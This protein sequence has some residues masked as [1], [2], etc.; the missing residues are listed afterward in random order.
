MKQSF[1]H[2]WGFLSVAAESYISRLSFHSNAWEYLQAAICSWS[3]TPTS[4][5]VCC[6]L[7]ARETRSVVRL[8]GG[9]SEAPLV[10]LFSTH[11]L[12]TKCVVA[13]NGS[14]ALVSDLDKHTQSSEAYLETLP[15]E[16]NILLYNIHGYISYKSNNHW[17]SCLGFWCGDNR[18]TFAFSYNAD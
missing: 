5:S 8:S 17:L 12:N 2:F 4:A 18:V 6:A 10:R 3:L 16:S 7:P 11:E 1:R 14:W 15:L 9:V 13:L